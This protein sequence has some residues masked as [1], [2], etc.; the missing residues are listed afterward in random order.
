MLNA[1]D[2]TL[3]AAPVNY[4]VGCGCEMESDAVSIKGIGKGFEIEVN[5]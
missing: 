4:K 2:S 1:V 3:K 5:P